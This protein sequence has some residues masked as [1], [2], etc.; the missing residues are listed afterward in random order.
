MIAYERRFVCG[1]LFGWA[2]RPKPLIFV[3][4]SGES[5][6]PKIVFANV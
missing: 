1:L 5:L 3:P 4:H 2:E 6:L